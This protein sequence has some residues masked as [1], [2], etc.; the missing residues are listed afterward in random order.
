MPATRKS[1]RLSGGAGAKQSTLSFNTR[2]TKSVPKS[3]KDVV[4]SKPSTLS[5]EVVVEPETKAIE[6]VPVAKVEETEIEVPE[7]T[8]VER[9]AEKVTAKEIERYWSK[10]DGARIAKA[11]HKKH[12]ADLTTGEKVLRYFDVSSQYGPCIGMSRLKR[13]QRAE[14]LGLKPPIEVLA[15]LL[16]EET[17]GNKDI[18]RAHMDELMNSTAAGA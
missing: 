2:V 17:A 8:E 3:A 4:V 5:K 1:S 11:T 10:I 6:D 14:K 9:K 7:K 16:R 13:W 12:T 15:V 18:E